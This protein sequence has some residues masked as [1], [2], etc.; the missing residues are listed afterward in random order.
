MR[1][2]LIARPGYRA[3]FLKS[4]GKITIASEEDCTAAIERNKVLEER[5]LPGEEF[6]HVAYVPRVV[7]QRAQNEGWDDGDWAKWLND[8]DHSKL[9]SWKGQIG[10]QDLL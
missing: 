1:H 5:A 8:P 3:T 7:A 2:P 9:R 10:R 4:D 6:R